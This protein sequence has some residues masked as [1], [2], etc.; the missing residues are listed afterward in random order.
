MKIRRKPAAQKVGRPVGQM[1]PFT[2]ENIQMLENLLKADGSSASIRDLALLRVGLDTMLRSIDLTS[3]VV[4]DVLRSGEVVIDF[5]TK[6]RK[7]KKPVHCEL[8]PRTREALAAWLQHAELSDPMARVFEISTRQHQRIIK[9]WCA[10]LRLD[11]TVYSTHSVRRTKPSV[12]YAKTQNVAAISKM[13]GHTNTV[14]TMAYLGV[15]DE[16]A[17]KLARE[18]DV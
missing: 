14:A 6:Q 9:Q 4:G 5:T 15:T 11:G 18:F 1:R 3:L 13:L 17:R 2:S 8:V 7:T 16:D 10:L 12:I